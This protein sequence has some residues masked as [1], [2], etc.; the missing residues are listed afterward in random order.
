MTVVL[1]YATYILWYTSRV[2]DMVTEYEM[3]D[4]YYH[5]PLWIIYIGI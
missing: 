1:G 2:A 4:V 5:N 3:N